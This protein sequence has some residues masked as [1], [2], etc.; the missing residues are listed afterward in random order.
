MLRRRHPDAGPPLRD[1]RP[2]KAQGSRSIE[3][4]RLLPSSRAKERK[5]RCNT[6]PLSRLG[7]ALPPEHPPSRSPS[8]RTRINGW[9]WRA[10]NPCAVPASHLV[11][12]QG[13]KHKCLRHVTQMSDGDQVRD[14]KGWYKLCLTGTRKGKL[15]LSSRP[16]FPQGHRSP[17]RQFH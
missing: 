17:C 5:R 9:I 4:S 16:L 8:K 3:Q 13:H 2:T 1:P 10:L 11:G 12:H 14:R 15:L 6:P 7:V